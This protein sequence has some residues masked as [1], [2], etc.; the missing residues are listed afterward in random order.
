MMNTSFRLLLCLFSGLSVWFTTSAQTPQ[1]VD[2]LVTTVFLKDGPGGSVIIAKEGRVL[3][4]KAFGKANLEH[5]IAMDT[6]HV[7]RLGSIT[8]QF[9][10]VCILKLA[11]EG[12]LSLH[13]EITKF[14]P[15]Y[16]ASGTKITI[17]H[18]LTHTAGVKNYTGL[19][20]FTE[21]L[22]RQ[23]LTPV[24]L[25]ALFKDQPLDFDP[26]SNHVYSN[27]GYILL[28][29]IIEKISGKPYGQYIHEN[30]FGPLGMKSS[31]Y[32]DRGLIIPN[33]LSG[34]RSRSGN[35]ANAEFLSMTLPY[36]AGSLLSTTH[37]LLTWYE[38][39]ARGK[40]IS[41]ASLEQA[42]T[43]FR[44]V[45]GKETGY[46]FGWEVGNVQGSKA[47][48]HTGVVNGF[49]AHVIYLPSERILVTILSNDENIGNLEI[50]AA[51][52]AAMALGKPYHF[53]A[54]SLAGRDLDEYQ[55]VYHNPYDGERYVVHQD[56]ELLHFF[57]GGSKTRLIPYDKDLFRMANTLT[58]LKF[59]RDG[60]GAVSGYQIKG[61][62]MP[63]DWQRSAQAVPL[64]KRLSL[65]TK[66]LE[67]YTGKFLFEPKMVFEVFLENNRLFARVGEDQK[68]LI[69]F[70]TNKFYAQDLDA[71]LIFNSDQQGRIS[72]ITKIQNSE[73][74]A[75]RIE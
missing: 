5:G 51:K 59:D 71:T 66:T 58:T 15:D 4:H 34:Y 70:E 7:F 9:T 36:A 39:L 19:P 60:Q 67:R 44:L 22:K 47:V 21:N 3:Y 62:G 55:A 14:I 69:P 28:G 72:S 48:K 8:K 56:G 63:S 16:P 32:D 30:I 6:N 11:Q 41:Q 57:R 27:S 46:G 18:L 13:D 74:Q 53:P 20:T 29:Y 10:A 17:A 26:G 52:L 73:M 23:D 35:Y 42:H 25:I 24:E 40:V 31:Y 49:F 65:P 38:A 68:E 12:K 75:K 54:L 1:S 61:P 45:S 37:D 64:R 50:S 43:C 33:R 2:S